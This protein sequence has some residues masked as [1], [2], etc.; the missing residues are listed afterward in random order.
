MESTGPPPEGD[1]DE[2]TPILIYVVFLITATIAIVVLRFI[3]RKFIT[4]TIGWD[5]WTILFA[6]IRKRLRISFCLVAKADD[7]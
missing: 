2:K 4:K 5:D 7:S 6:L 1:V 3:V